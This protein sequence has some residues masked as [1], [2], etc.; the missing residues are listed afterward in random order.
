MNWIK[1]SDCLINI[2]LVSSIE[3]VGLSITIIS[4]DNAFDALATYLLNFR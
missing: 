2:D 4:N 1:I 3:K